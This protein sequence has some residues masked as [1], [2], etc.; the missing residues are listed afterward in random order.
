M[1]LPEFDFHQRQPLAVHGSEQRHCLW[2]LLA[3][4]RGTRST[5]GTP[6]G[7]ERVYARHQWCQ[8]LDMASDQSGVGV[9]GL[10][11]VSEG[12]RGMSLDG[13]VAQVG[14]VLGDAGSFYGAA[15]QGGG[16]SIR[17]R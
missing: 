11:W 13:L 3:D 12:L 17:R 9:S 4:S 6:T 1:P 16:W 8:R 2:T 14:Q 15:P 7:S 10:W 5:A